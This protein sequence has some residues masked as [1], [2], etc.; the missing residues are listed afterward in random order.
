MKSALLGFLDAVKR[1]RGRFLAV[2]CAM[3]AVAGVDIFLPWA[4]RLYIDAVGSSENGRLVLAAGLAGFLL[5]LLLRTGLN[6]AKAVSW[7][8]F[9]KSYIRRLTLSLQERMAGADFAAIEAL[10]GGSIRNI[11]H[12]DVLNALRAVSNFLPS[13]AMSLIIVAASLA[14]SLCVDASI[15]GILCAAISVG[16]LLSWCSRKSLQRRAGKTNQALKKQ[17]AWCTQFVDMLPTIQSND[18]LEYYQ[19]GAAANLDAF[20]ETAIEEDKAI[21]FWS[22]TVNGYNT[23]LNILISAVL[24]LPSAGGSI[25]NLVF[26]TTIS[27]L[28]MQHVQTL[29][30]LF[31]QVVKLAPSFEHIETLLSLPQAFGSQTL[32]PVRRVEWQNVQFTYPN[33]TQALA[34]ISCELR[35]K[36]CI[37][38]TGHNGSGKSTFIKLLTG[39]YLPTGGSIRLN[40]RPLTDYSR[41]SLHEQILYVGQ[42]EKFLNETFKAYLDIASG[43]AVPQEAYAQWLRFVDLPDDGRKIEGNGLSLS[44]GQRKKLL[45]M[46][47][48]SR[49]ARASVIILDEL[50]AGMDV[51]AKERVFRRLQSLMQGQDKIL[52]LVEHG[53]AQ[54]LPFTKVFR[55]AEGRLEVQEHR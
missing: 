29:E 54:E 9:G 18:Y 45:V 3:F 31:Q 14:L 26:Y 6:I 47:L 28:V 5:L 55:F 11:L 36:D 38:L 2:A 48:F 41:S 37:L 17:D 10:P 7:D 42:E 1:Y 15:T 40:G 52:L 35:P 8:R 22:G 23:L 39:L 27:S 30:S 49:F 51:E 50:A 25:A 13:M 16:V 46:K 20:I 19:K 53:L 21:Y 33:G 34:G 44:A 24:A 32:A 4:L 43:E 12:S